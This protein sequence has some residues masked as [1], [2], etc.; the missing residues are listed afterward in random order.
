MNLSL[1]ITTA[2]LTLIVWPAMATDIHVFTDSAHPVRSLPGNVTVIKL[3][4]G[5]RLE[6]ELSE[7]LPADQEQAA[8]L[9]Q[10][11]LE[12]GGPTLQ[13]R[14]ADAYQNVAEAWGLGVMKIPAVVVDRRYVVYGEPDVELALT[15]ITRY[16]K[17]HP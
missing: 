9:V 6:N 10:R 16:R 12:Q 7:N 5:E 13:H 2:V 11:R 3:D 4:A 17:E 1:P 8:R 14:M 15:S